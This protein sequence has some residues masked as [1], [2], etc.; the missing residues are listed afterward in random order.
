[1]VYTATLAFYLDNAFE[2]AGLVLQ[3][4]AEMVGLE[5][6]IGPYLPELVVDPLVTGACAS[7][8]HARA[9]D[10]HCKQAGKWAGY[11]LTCAASAACSCLLAE[12][13]Q[14]STLLFGAA[15]SLILTRKLGARPW[16]Q[17]VPQC[18]L[19]LAFTV[20]VCAAQRHAFP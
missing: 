20:E 15:L 6:A 12:F 19:I 13:L 14:G 4:F 5:G 10:L 17:L 11:N 1:M 18:A 8:M 7:A 2:E 16:A 9:A 3:V